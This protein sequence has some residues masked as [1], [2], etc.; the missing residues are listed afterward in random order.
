[1]NRDWNEAQFDT[2]SRLRFEPTPVSEI[3]YT[4]GIPRFIKAGISFYF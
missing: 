1:M 3:H 4:P 2:E